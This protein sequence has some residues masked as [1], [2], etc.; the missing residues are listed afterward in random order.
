MAR[1]TL[2]L[3]A[4]F[5]GPG[6][7]LFG[8]KLL[9][10]ALL[11]AAVSAGNDAV[12]TAQAGSTRGVRDKKRFKAGAVKRGTPIIWPRNKTD[13]HALEWR[14]EASGAPVRLGDVPRRQTKRGVVVEVNRGVRRLVRGAF[15]ARLKSGHVGVFRRRGKTRL[16]I[17][18]GFTSTIADVFTDPGFAPRVIERGMTRGL[19]T[20][21][22]LFAIEL[23][24]IAQQPIQFERMR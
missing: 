12:R 20:F 11:K 2:T 13:L 16:P 19:A 1:N 10:R 21:E 9:D 6:L 22:R 17:D 5:G 23:Q 4:Q 3:E 7:R 8:D 24:R 15:I 14:L 18:E